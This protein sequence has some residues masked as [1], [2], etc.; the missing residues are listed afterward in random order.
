MSQWASRDY[1][2]VGN[3]IN[4]AAIAAR[5]EVKVFFATNSQELARHFALA[6][7]IMFA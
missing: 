2:K 4:Y 5:G 1:R 7:I 3:V 6:L